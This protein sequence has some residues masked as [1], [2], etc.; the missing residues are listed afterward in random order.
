MTVF[1]S[2]TAAK[3]FPLKGEKKRHKQKY[4]PTQKVSTT[5]DKKMKLY[6]YIAREERKK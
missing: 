3:T 1:L 5:K 6:S 4:S 2:F